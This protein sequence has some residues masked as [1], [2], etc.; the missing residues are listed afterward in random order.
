MSPPL[1]RPVRA[2][3][4]D[5]ILGLLRELATYERLDHRFRLTVEIIARDF[6]CEPP[7]VRCELAFIDQERAGI[8]TWH[9]T[10]SSF[11][12]TRGLYLEDFYVRSE[13]R[14]HGIGR[15]LLGRLARHATDTGVTKIEWSVLKWNRPAIDFYESV[16]AER[17]DDWHVYRLVGKALADIAAA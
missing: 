5:I 15:A 12:G 7:A 2:G 3:D 4:E 13:L 17:V 1:I 10:Y 11:S 16:H 9:S 8:M 6:F 14:R